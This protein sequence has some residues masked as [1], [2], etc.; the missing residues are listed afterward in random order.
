LV[1]WRKCPAIKV[2]FRLKHHED[3]Q[4]HMVQS[5]PCGKG[6]PNWV[7]PVPLHPVLLQRC[8]GVDCDEVWSAIG[9]VSTLWVLMVCAAGSDL[10]ITQGDV[11]TAFLNSEL[12]ETIYMRQPPG[13]EDGIQQ[14]WRLRKAIFR[15]RQ[16]ARA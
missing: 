1:S 3:G 8:N 14:V 12:R 16:G 11:D 4:D 9:S 15:L 6:S 7:N 10:H 5:V 13:I 2:G